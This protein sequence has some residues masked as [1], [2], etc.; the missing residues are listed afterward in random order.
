LDLLGSA[1]RRC[2]ELLRWE[3]LKSWGHALKGY[4][5]ISFFFLADGV[6]AFF[7]HIFP[8][9]YDALLEAQSMRPSIM[10]LNL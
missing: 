7:C 5:S 3:V 9:G 10:D 2:Y 4:F 8:P 6:T 1:I